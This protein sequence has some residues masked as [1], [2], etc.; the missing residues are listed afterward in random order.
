MNMT[1]I[2]FSRDALLADIGNAAYVAADVEEGSTESHRLHQTF[3][4]CQEDNIERIDRLLS[5]AYSEARLRLLPVIA[6]GSG[7]RRRL[8]DVEAEK[9]DRRLRLCL[10]E[11]GKEIRAA[12]IRDAVHEFLIARVVGWWLSVTLPASAGAWKERGDRLGESLEAI[13][14]EA[15][16]TRAGTTVCRRACSPF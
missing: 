1:E 12:G 11:N 4:I 3:D 8:S 14:A 15:S 7:H 6:K 10:P 13:A 2:T 16:I 9:R 5:L